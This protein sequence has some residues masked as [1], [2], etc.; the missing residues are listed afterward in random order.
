[1]ASMERSEM[2]RFQ[3]YNLYFSVLTPGRYRQTN[4]FYQLCGELAR[5]KQL[6]LTDDVEIN[7]FQKIDPLPLEQARSALYALS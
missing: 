1:M 5:K 2:Y 3:I 4:R 7:N 6:F